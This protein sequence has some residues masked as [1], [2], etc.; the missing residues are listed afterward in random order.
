MKTY[1]ILIAA[2]FPLCLFGQSIGRDVIAASGA[3]VNS[4][5]AHLS[6]TIG[7]AVIWQQASGTVVLSQGF[8]QPDG[9]GSVAIT[10]R[11]ELLD[12][13]VFPN[14]AQGGIS[15]AFDTRKK[16]ELQISLVNAAGQ[17]VRDLGESVNVSGKETL[18]MDLSGLSSGIY[19]LQLSGPEHGIRESVRV[20]KID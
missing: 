5:A 2:F 19:F 7:E 18:K 1:L 11:Q 15:I 12:L 4:S 17:R 16:L 8:Q 20:H 14:P 9:G 10:D 3:S 13:T 6:Y